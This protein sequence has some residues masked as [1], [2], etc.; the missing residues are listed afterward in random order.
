V[1]S[2]EVVILQEAVEVTLN[3]GGLEIPGGSPGD[4]EA[5]VEEGTIHAHEAIGA[6]RADL[7]GPTLAAIHRQEQLEGM[8][9]GPARITPPL[10]VRIAPIAI[11]SA[12]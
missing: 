6:R 5:L 11:P 7:R 3:L 12:S 1:G 9:I 4:P 2:L 8:L 10:S